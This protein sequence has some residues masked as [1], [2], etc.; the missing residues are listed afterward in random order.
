MILIKY[1]KWRQK[2]NVDAIAIE[3]IQIN[4]YTSPKYHQKFELKIF[5]FIFYWRCFIYAYQWL[6]DN[7]VKRDVN[8]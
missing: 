4:Q 2:I 5:L 3:T 8:L 1:E 7:L 6:L